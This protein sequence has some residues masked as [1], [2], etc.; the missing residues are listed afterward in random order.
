MRILFLD[1]DGV[2]MP[3]S[4]APITSDFFVWVPVLY[5]ALREHD[6]VRIVV[7]S[8]WRYDTSIDELRDLLGV[9]L[10]PLV[11]DVTPLW[12]Q[13]YEGIVGWLRACRRPVHS[14]RILD[15]AGKEFPLPHP[16]ELIL[17]HPGRGVDDPAVL[18]QLRNWLS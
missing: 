7:H 2:L 8:S 10:G 13:R 9:F 6:D 12:M 5:R 3:A 15:D 14:Y 4:S 11:I 1:F 18:L 17:C 16:N